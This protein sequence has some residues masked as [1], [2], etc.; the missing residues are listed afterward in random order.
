[1]KFYYLSTTKYPHNI[2]N[3]TTISQGYISVSLQTYPKNIQRWIKGQS[4]IQTFYG[5]DGLSNT[6]ELPELYYEYFMPSAFEAVKD[7]L[8]Y[9]SHEIYT[10]MLEEWPVAYLV[11]P[12]AA[13]TVSEN[14]TYA[15]IS[16]H[17]PEGLHYFRKFE[18]TEFKLVTETFVERC[19][20]LKLKGI[21]FHLRWDGQ[22]SYPSVEHLSRAWL[23]EQMRKKGDL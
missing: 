22:K 3:S 19:Q 11:R 7:L 5:R 15:E 13:P 9:P 6:I 20:Q 17:L 4:D 18:E 14:P 8:A 12:A 21:K 1:M 16:A 10:L 23:E 2:P